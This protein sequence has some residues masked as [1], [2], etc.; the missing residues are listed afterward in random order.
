MLQAKKISLHK[1]FQD[2]DITFNSGECWHILG[3]NGA[4]KSSLFDVLSGLVEADIGDVTYQG[5]ALS[6]ISISERATNRAYL[7]Q[8]YSLAFSL[9]VA[10]LLRFYVDQAT[11][12]QPLMSS[13]SNREQF[14]I[15]ADLDK[16]LQIN[17]LLDRPLNELSGGEQQRVHIAR[18]LL[19]V[20]PAIQQGGATLL[21]DE[22]LQNLDIA[23][24]ES[25]LNLFA[26]FVSVG[27]L[28]IMSV[29]DVNLSLR[30]A[31]KVLLL[32]QGKCQASGDSR[33]ML[34]ASGI[35]EL[36]EYPFKLLQLNNNLEK[37]FI[38][39]PS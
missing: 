39:R 13:N 37:T 29:H 26:K 5:K 22:P 10:E 19:Q 28:L 38:R 17:S 20:W 21:M 3:Q 30:F 8:S 35:T 33:A 31:D 6:Q 23:F 12:I 32:K 27:N 25:V 7:Q 11:F 24:Q 34:T 4:G 14:T 16:A 36:Y 2:I 1:R 15:P 9:S 18:V